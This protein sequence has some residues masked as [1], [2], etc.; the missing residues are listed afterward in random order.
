MLMMKKKAF[1]Y[2]IQNY[3]TLLNAYFIV[4][5]IGNNYY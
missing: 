5:T 2:K 3:L 4:L 1:F